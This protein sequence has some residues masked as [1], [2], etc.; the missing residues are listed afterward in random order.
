VPRSPAAELLR[1]VTAALSAD[2]E[3][4]LPG[5]LRRGEPGELEWSDGV[6][7]VPVAGVGTLFVTTPPPDEDLLA[8][9]EAAGALISLWN[10]TR[11]YDARRRAMLDVAFDS[12]VTMDERGY[13][14]A[15]NRAAERTFGY[16]AHEMVGR[17]VADV[18]IPPSLR[19]AHRAGLER[20][21]RTGRGPVVGRRVE[22]TAMRKDG[23]EF[24]VELVV[25]RPDVPGE[26][27][28]YGY[29][30]DLT[31]RY[32]AEATLHRLADEQAA[33]RRV[34]TAVAAELDPSQLFELVTEEVAR[35]LE[36]ETAALM[37]FDGDV[38]VT[39]GAHNKPGVRGVPVGTEMPLRADTAAGRVF[40]T[41][42]PARIDDYDALDGEVARELQ[43][44]G[45][46]SS[47][48]APVFLG[49][50]LWGAMVLLSVNEQRF[51]EDAEQRIAYF[52]ELA[53][54]A[55]ANA[56]A[57]EELG[58]SRARIVQAG[59]E[60]RRRL[61]RNLHDGAQQRLVSLALML[62]LAA[63]RHPDDEDLARAGEELSHALQELRELAR[64]IHPAVLT[65]RGLEPALRA[66]ADRAP[67]PV[68]LDFVPTSRLPGP[69][70][71]AAYYVVSEA[72]TN[73]AK[74][75][76]A[77]LVRVRVE[78]NGTSALI[79]VTDD[80]AGGADPRG[81]SGLR[82]LADRVEALGGR[83]TVESPLGEGTTLRAALP[84][85]GNPPT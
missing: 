8:A 80:G 56:Q 5:E 42:A 34:A 37:R 46:R 30:R 47:V 3:G 73:V 17:L 35:L 60:E 7:S 57:R 61:E 76:G 10:D 33:L 19:E 64:G 12:V 58:A 16:G 45:F 20:Y 43:R 9:A 6:L 51:P 74:Y 67:V 2:D 85:S 69:V 53:A 24:P 50:R 84:I 68:E 71:A 14:L 11:E 29:L 52:A 1:A 25:T 27:V 59:D 81:G 13:V 79:E 44:V 63:R 36:A 21:L 77:S 15:V 28:F 18:I 70:E 40:R 31:A 26:R 54:Q 22:L 48:A 75:A 66:L 32:R 38:A 65:E 82:G 72:L 4:R 78:Q 49:G 83:L 62:R 41:G 23:S 55:L 39:V